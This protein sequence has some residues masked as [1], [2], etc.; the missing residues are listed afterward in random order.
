ML[1]KELYTS[2]VKEG[3]HSGVLATFVEFGVN[4][5]DI[6]LPDFYNLLVNLQET[7]TIVFRNVDKAILEELGPF[8]TQHCVTKRLVFDNCDIDRRYI[9]VSDAWRHNI[10]I[11]RNAGPNLDWD[12]DEL[13]VYYTPDIITDFLNR[14]TEH[15][16]YTVK[17]LQTPVLDNYEQVF[18][19]LRECPGWTFRETLNERF[20]FIR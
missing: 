1:I 8:I 11:A 9:P 14:L 18:N 15:Y 6:Q 2:F 12:I 16:R 17:I 3:W 13:K 10:W 20:P 19:L 4:C 7:D 5:W